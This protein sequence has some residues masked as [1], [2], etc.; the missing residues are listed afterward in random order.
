MDA[1]FGAIEEMLKMIR[2]ASQTPKRAERA[3]MLTAVM[4]LATVSVFASLA[5]L[6]HYLWH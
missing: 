2:I 1:L 4:A 5:L 6:A 3:A